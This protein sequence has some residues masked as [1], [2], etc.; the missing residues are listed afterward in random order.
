MGYYQ[1]GFECVGVDCIDQPN[2]PY[3]FIKAD[4]MEVLNDTAFMAQFD[5]IH[6]SPPCQAYS[7][8]TPLKIKSDKP[9]LVVP[10]RQSLEK[11]GLPYIIENVPEAKKAGLKPNL[12]LAGHIFGLR[13]I[14]KRIF[15]LS[16]NLRALCPPIHIPKP[17]GSVMT[18]EFL[19][20]AGMGCNKQETPYYKGK[21]KE[22]QEKTLL[23]NREIAM[24]IDWL[25]KGTNLQKMREITNA[26]PPAYTKFIGDKIIHHFK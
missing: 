7:I 11:I 14:R 17:I 19:T 18:G 20:C 12:L 26:I 15:E 3:E 1:A 21:L 4:A 23:Q 10:L 22:H 6:A 16:P 9:D 24:G 25:K 13:V 8:A 5:V 2:C